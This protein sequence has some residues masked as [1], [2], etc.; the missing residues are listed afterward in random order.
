[1]KRAILLACV[2]V[3]ALTLTARGQD[4]P[5]A[6]PTPP[7]PP[8][9]VPLATQAPLGGVIVHGDG[10][11]DPAR[12]RKALADFDAFTDL[13]SAASVVVLSRLVMEAAAGPGTRVAL[14]SATGGE[15]VVAARV[16]GQLEA[17]A[18]ETGRVRWWNG[19]SVVYLLYA[20]GKVDL[21]DAAAMAGAFDRL[22]EAFAL[23]RGGVT[24]GV[25]LMLDLEGL[26]R[27]WPQSLADGPARRVVAKTSL[28]NARKVH[29]HLPE[30]GPVRLAYSSRAKPPDSVTVR[31]GRAP[32][33]ADTIGI[34]VP[35]LID[36][37]VGSYMVSLEAEELAL[38]ER[39]FREWMG[40]DG[41]RLRRLVGGPENG[42]RWTLVHT[43]GG[44]RTTVE[45]AMMPVVDAAQAF[46]TAA[47]ALTNLGF[48]VEGQRAVLALPDAVARALGG[49]SLS[50]EMDT[51]QR[52][53]MLRVVVE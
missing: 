47:P 9:P 36:M 21:N 7:P 46:E 41:G 18:D 8:P 27:A 53:A 31:T 39:R 38:F 20:R 11:T 35:N 29:V 42:G 16:P 44:L 2:A 23:Q 52:P 37:S 17:S 15:P 50:I 30:T 1:M 43:E 51:T 24:G 5:K 49:S 25:E 22:E 26:R 34:S 14:L 19:D 48:V 13:D 45:V 6:A 3:L 40:T 28:A 33:P 12:V 10:P 4:E 32:T